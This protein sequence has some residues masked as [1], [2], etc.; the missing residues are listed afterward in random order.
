VFYA[1]SPPEETAW[2]VPR[3][4]LVDRLARDWPDARVF[5]PDIGESRDV[6]WEIRRDG[7]VLEGSQ[8]LAGQAQYLTG[9]V[10]IVA[11]YA[12]WWRG[13]V[14]EAQPL[15]LYDEGYSFV[16]ELPFGIRTADIL[17]QL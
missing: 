3:L 14:A 15:V 1:I 13:Q 5:G 7:E 12:A 8:D 4:E 6:V 2:H 9:P 17:R 11:A 16:I 10:E